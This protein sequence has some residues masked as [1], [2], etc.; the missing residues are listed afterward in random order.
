MNKTLKR[1]HLYAILVLLLCFSLLFKPSFFQVFAPTLTA[2]Y[3]I[4]FLLKKR[5]FKSCL[6][7][8]AMFLPAAAVVL[9]QMFSE[10]GGDGSSGGGMYIYFARGWSFHTD[11]IFRSIMTFA[12]FLLFV[13][14]FCVEKIYNNKVLYCSLMFYLVGVAEGLFLCQSGSK[15]SHGNFLWG[16]NLGIGIGFLG[17]ICCFYNYCCKNRCNKSIQHRLIKYSG[18]FILLMHLTLGI[19]YILRALYIGLEY[20]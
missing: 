20:F 8:A 12:I 16:N 4:D 19:W 7:D 5:T 11:S 3:G 9:Y 10:F 18:Y 6:L 1:V 17:A 15:V 13:S 14:V 2:I